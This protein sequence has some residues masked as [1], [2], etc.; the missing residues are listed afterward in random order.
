VNAPALPV[1]VAAAVGLEKV[2]FGVVRAARALR[3]ARLTDL[4]RSGF[5]RHYAVEHD[6]DDHQ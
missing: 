2:G 3:L 6:A 5:A 4:V 1:A